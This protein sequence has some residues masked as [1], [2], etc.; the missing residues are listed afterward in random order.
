MTQATVSVAANAT[1][2]AISK[3]VLETLIFPLWV[4][5]LLGL[6]GYLANL[7]YQRRS[8]RLALL[9]D[10]GIILPF[11]GEIKE[12]LAHADH[13]WL[14]PGAMLSSAPAATSPTTMLFTALIPQLYLLPKSEISRVLRFYR[15]WELCEG[16]TKSLYE[17]IAKHAASGQA[18]TLENVQRLI[19]RRNRICTGLNSLLEVAGKPIASLGDLP[20][21]YVIPSTK[22]TL[23][24]L[25]GTSAAAHAAIPIAP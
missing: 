8:I 25:L 3:A 13:D 14:V 2:E 1:A 15:H 18:L 7:W 11:A 17:R 6:I 4:G 20:D 19:V 16:L 23:T 12:Y 21:S 10:I 22:A 9:V 24:Q 5:L